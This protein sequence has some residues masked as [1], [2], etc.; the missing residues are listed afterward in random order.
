MATT[1]K[2]GLNVVVAES[3]PPSFLRQPPLPRRQGPRTMSRTRWAV[4]LAVPPGSRDS[5]SCLT[6][7]ARSGW[8]WSGCCFHDAVLTEPIRSFHPVRG[9]SHDRLARTACGS[10]SD[11]RPPPPCPVRVAAGR[12]GAT[13]AGPVRDP[14]W[15]ADVWESAAAGA[16]RGA[17]RGERRHRDS[18]PAYQPPV[19]GPLAAS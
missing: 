15:L 1:P 7:P 9:W 13:H 18:G 8:G 10:R 17:C 12:L 2:S 11:P 3:L 16:P 6:S 14:W 4:K 5:P 19:R